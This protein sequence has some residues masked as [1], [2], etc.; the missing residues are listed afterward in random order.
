MEQKSEVKDVFE[1]MLEINDKPVLVDCVVDPDDM[2]P[3]V[4]AGGSNDVIILNEEDLKK[5]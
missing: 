3:M 4:P 2:V 5:I 1:K